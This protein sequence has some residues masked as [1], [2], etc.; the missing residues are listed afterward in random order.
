MANPP[1]A[2]E[3]IVPPHDLRHSF[4]TRLAE[5][6]VP[7]S[8]MLALLGHMSRRMLERYSHIRMAAKRD[9]VAGLTLNNKKQKLETSPTESP[10]ISPSSKIQ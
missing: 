4:A 10:T 3:R 1:Q 8:T 6:G 9:A 2:G 7:E 5:T